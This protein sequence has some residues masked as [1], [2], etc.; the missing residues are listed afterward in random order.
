MDASCLV[1]ERDF[2]NAFGLTAGDDLVIILEIAPGFVL[3]RHTVQLPLADQ[4]FWRGSQVL[5]TPPIHQEE[6]A[7]MVLG[8]DG[9]WDE[10]DDLPLP[11]FTVPS[12]QNM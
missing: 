5:G 9:V 8:E 11:R 1:R 2:R 6:A 4:R 7:D 10:V 12:R 3:H